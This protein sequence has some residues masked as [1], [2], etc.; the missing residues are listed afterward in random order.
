MPIQSNMKIVFWEFHDGL[1]GK[2]NRTDHQIKIGLTH[3]STT[4]KPTGIYFTWKYLSYK[5]N[6]VFVNCVCQNASNIVEG[7][8]V[9]LIELKELLEASRRSFMRVFQE[10]L[11]Q[12]EIDLQIPVYSLPDDALMPTLEKLNGSD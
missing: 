12:L 10:R 6:F 8:T 2:E 7:K 1:P 3:N 11:N 5:N 4:H 9:S